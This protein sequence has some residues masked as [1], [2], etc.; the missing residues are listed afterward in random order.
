MDRT[1]QANGFRKVSTAPDFWVGYHAAIEGKLDVTTID[2]PYF[3]PTGADIMRGGYHGA[4]AYGGSQTFVTQYEEGTLLLDIVDSQTK[5]LI[6]RGT[7]SAV[8]DADAE[9]EKRKARI[10]EAVQKA[11]AD[12][13][14]V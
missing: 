13:P 14:P 5:K 9:P 7:V 4:W 12:F 3:A 10:Q 6:W 8:V 1:L 2:T 11:L